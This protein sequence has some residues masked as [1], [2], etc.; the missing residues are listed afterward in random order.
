MIGDQPQRQI[1]SSQQSVGKHAW[2]VSYG[3]S[4][5]HRSG[6]YPHHSAEFTNITQP[7]QRSR[8]EIAAELDFLPG[9]SGLNIAHEAAT[10]HANN[11]HS[12][13]VAIR[14]ISKH[15]AIYDFTMP[16]SKRKAPLANVLQ[17]LA[18]AKVSAYLSSPGAFALYFAALGKLKHECLSVRFSRILGP[19][20]ILVA[21]AA[22]RRSRFVDDTE[23]VQ[24][25]KSKRFFLNCLIKFVLIADIDEHISIISC[26]CRY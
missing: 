1:H 5:S 15:D 3:F 20:P 17:E 10:R 4:Q 21:Y 23:V 26:H 14:W 2:E 6:D 12:E 11:A 16:M 18:L 22:W 19:E 9:E 7:G 24:G 13:Q 8:D 25:A